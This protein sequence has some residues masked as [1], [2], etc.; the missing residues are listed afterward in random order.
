MK[1]YSIKATSKSCKH[2]LSFRYKVFKHIILYK[3]LEN[4]LKAVIFPA[5]VLFH[6]LSTVLQPATFIQHIVSRLVS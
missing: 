6:L 5:C 3:I 1:K 4:T 2:D